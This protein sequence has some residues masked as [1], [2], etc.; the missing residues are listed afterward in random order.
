MNAFNISIDM[1]RHWRVG[2]SDD[3]HVTKKHEYAA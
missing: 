2:I 3:A 1:V